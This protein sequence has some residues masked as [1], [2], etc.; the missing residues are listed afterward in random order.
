MLLALL[1][2]A[3]CL[4]AGSGVY[5]TL[6]LRRAYD[7]KKWGDYVVGPVMLVIGLAVAT[8]GFGFGFGLL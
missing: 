8:V 1:G 2:L 5:M 3:G 4:I 6:A 7:G